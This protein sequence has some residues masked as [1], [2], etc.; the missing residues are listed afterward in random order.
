MSG[1]WRAPLRLKARLSGTELDAE[2]QGTA[3]P[4]A[5]EPKAAVNLSVRRAN[6]APLLDRDSSDP[7][8]RNFSLSSRLTLAGSKLIFDDM[9]S[10]AGGARIRG[11]VALNLGDATSVDGE[12]GMDAL[13]LA[14]AFGLAISRQRSGR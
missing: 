14:P 4:W 5:S 12:V 13:D 9:D 3:E 11:R 2:A 1:A 7:L 6:L 8:A 10:A